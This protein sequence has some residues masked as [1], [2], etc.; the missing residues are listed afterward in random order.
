MSEWFDCPCGASYRN[1]EA[2]ALCC[3]VRG[4]VAIEQSGLEDWTAA[5]FQRA[6][7]LGGDDA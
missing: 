1:R 6:S 3:G 2:A 4:L 5:A 7:E